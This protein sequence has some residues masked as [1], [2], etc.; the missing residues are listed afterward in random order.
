MLATTK[1]QCA[2]AGSKRVESDDE[3]FP[4][5]NGFCLFEMTGTMDALICVLVW[6]DGITIGSGC[7]EE[8]KK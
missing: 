1:S 8:A 5:C 4:S 6:V 7:Q 3:Q 2:A